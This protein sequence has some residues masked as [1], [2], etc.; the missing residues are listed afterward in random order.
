MIPISLVPNL[1]VGMS[2]RFFHILFILSSILCSAGYVLWAASRFEEFGQNYYLVSAMASAF[3]C[4]VLVAYLKG[5]IVK[6][7]GE[8]RRWQQSLKV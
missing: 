4:V 6:A 7:G 3:G 2:L 5:A 1:E 8:V